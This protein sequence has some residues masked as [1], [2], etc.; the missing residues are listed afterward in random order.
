MHQIA[1]WNVRGL[2]WPDKQEDVKLFLHLN[3]I[4]MVGLLETKIKHQ[5]IETIAS[6]IFRGWE[7]TNNFEISKGRIWVA[8]KPCSYSLTPLVKTDQLIHCE[9]TQLSTSK[10]FHIT[11]IYGHNHELQR[12]PLWEDLHQIS[13]S[14]QGAWCIL[15]DFNSILYKDDRIGGNEV[16][17]HDTLELSAFMDSC[18]VQ[19]MTGSGAVFTWTNKT[20]WSK[21]DRVFINCLWHEEFD[22]T[23]V[24][25]LPPGLSDHSPLL[26]HFHAPPRP[27]P[28]FH[29][30]DMWSSHKNF[31]SIVEAC[32]PVINIHNIMH[33][34]K[35]FLSQLRSHLSQLNRNHFKD[36][37]IQQEIARNELH[38]LQQDLQSSP[39]NAS[40]KHQEKEARKKYGSI[41]S[42]CIALLKQQCKIEWIKYGDD[43]TR[44]FFAK[45]KQRKMATYIFSLHDA[46]GVEVEGFDKVG[47]VLHAFYT[48]LLGRTY[49]PHTPLDTS[50]IS[51]GD[52][53]SMEQ[54]IDLCKAFTDADI[55][56]ALFSIPNHKSPGPDG[57]SSGFFKS[58][59]SST[60]PLVCHMV[61][62]FFQSGYMP[63]FI[64]ATK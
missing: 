58:T 59:W 56:E 20:I 11:F 2:N 31:Q 18:E 26:L 53:L 30:C 52:S 17:E 14:I 41:L 1:S 40:L 42:S 4:G 13:L 46:S 25:A 35:H 54:Q 48:D 27:P 62:Q 12:Q 7:W 61:K 50:T 45:A 55:K 19:E 8:W 47:E 57:F 29:Y 34:A 10:H 33:Q 23:M 15:G 49:M 63:T 51:L 39:E 37:K 3:K 21:I 24:K 6:N 44:L 16:T 32:L 9:A 43:C 36:L 5:K 22:Y 60:D 64:S 28:Q 38:R